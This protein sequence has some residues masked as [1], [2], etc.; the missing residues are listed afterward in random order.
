[1]VS[2]AVGGSMAS[3]L[4]AKL[5]AS[6]QKLL[7]EDEAN[8]LVELHMV[9]DK[10]AFADA[11]AMNAQTAHSAAIM[12]S[13]QMLL[14]ADEANA[15]AEL[16]LLSEKIAFADAF[17]MNAQAVEAA[18]LLESRQMLVEAEEANSVAQLQL[19]SEKMRAEESRQLFLTLDSQMQAAQE[20]VSDAVQKTLT[21][22]EEYARQLPGALPGLGFWD[23]LGILTGSTE[24]KVQYYRDAEL[25]HG[26]IGTLAAIGILVEEVYH[27]LGG[28]ELNGVPAL[29]AFQHNLLLQTAVVASMAALASRPQL[30]PDTER[31]QTTEIWHVRG[32]MLAAFG[33]ICQEAVTNTCLICV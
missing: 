28:D 19:L 26:R 32:G 24:E 33:M 2:L 18:S 23:P 29:L 20:A 13:R 8:G 30:V 21:S 4:P 25:K 11:F 7:E 27:P 14:E 10:L 12:E 1:V 5:M 16:Q 31:K 22:G 17:A 3:H 15:V 9:E 6:R